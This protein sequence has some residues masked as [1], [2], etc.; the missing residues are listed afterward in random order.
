VPHRFR[1]GSPNDVPRHRERANAVLR[2]VAAVGAA[3]RGIRP[4]AR[5]TGASSASPGGDGRPHLTTVAT[6]TTK[7]VPATASGSTTHRR[8][9]RARDG[10]SWRSR[11]RPP[12]WCTVR[13]GS[14]LRRGS[15][16]AGRARDRRPRPRPPRHLLSH[17]DPGARRARRGAALREPCPGGDRR[18]LGVCGLPRGDRRTTPRAGAARCA[19][20]PLGRRARRG[21]RRRPVQ[22]E[23]TLH[24]A[25]PPG[26]DQPRPLGSRPPC[27]RRNA[28]HGGPAPDQSSPPGPATRDRSSAR[29]DAGPRG[30]CCR[31][32]DR[33]VRRGGGG[34]GPR[35]RLRHSEARRIRTA[36]AGTR[37]SSPD[38]ENTGCRASPRT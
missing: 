37:R 30:P 20:D 24:A 15:R 36:R 32:C 17:G 16:S 25:G 22:R 35:G 3:G 10:S 23:P 29:P 31:T 8:R 34:L 6:P 5:V 11:G 4:L 27:R 2:V 13:P 7:P 26:T 1:Q 33:A 21:A 12:R 14:C 9:S 28:H 18:T 38:K 19:R